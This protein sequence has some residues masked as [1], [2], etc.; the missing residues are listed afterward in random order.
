MTS[1]RDNKKA[2]QWK[3]RILTVLDKFYE[4]V[5]HKF[6]MKLSKKLGVIIVVTFVGIVIVGSTSIV[7]MYRLDSKMEQTMTV[8]LVEMQ[9]AGDMQITA[10]DYD[11]KI[12]GYIRDDN[13][14][15]RQMVMGQIDKLDKSIQ[16]DL[17]Q[18]A[19]L[20]TSDPVQSKNLNELK[21]N[22]QAYKDAQKKVLG[23]ADGGSAVIAF[24]LWEGNMAASHKKL[25]DTLDKINHDNQQVVKGSKSL[26]D[27][28]YTSS[29]VITLAVIVVIAVFAGALGLATNRYLQRRI[30][31]LVI[32]NDVLA[33]GD[34]TIDP[35]IVSHD[36]F[37]QLATSTTKV[38]ANLREIIGQ[39]GSASYQ[40]AAASQRMATSV[41]ESSRASE[42][43]AATIQEVAEGANRQVE[44]SQES[45]ELMQ[46][47]AESVGAIKMTMDQVV[48]MAQETAETAL[49]GRDVLNG[50]S[51]QIEGIRTANV[52]TVSAFETLYSEMNRII[53][54][55]NVITE[56]ASQTNLLALNAAIEAA[57][58]GEH[59]RGF[60]VV[61]GEVKKLADQSSTAAQQVRTIVDASRQ[62]LEQMKHALSGTNKRVDDGVQQMQRTNEGFETIVFSVEEMVE[63]IRVVADT[64][65]HIANNANQV[66]ANIEDVASVVE[67]S[68]AGMQEVSAATEEQLAGMQEISSS[69]VTLAQ[70][71]EQM[72]HAV[73]R[74]KVEESAFT[75][76]NWEANA[77]SEA[78]AFEAEA[79]AG[80]AFE[81]ADEFGAESNAFEA[82]EF[83][84]ESN[85]FEA[86]EFGVESN[87]F[88]ET[89]DFGAGS[90]AFAE[91]NDFGA[92]SNAFE[93]VNDFGAES[94]AFEAN[95]F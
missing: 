67:E 6:K 36:E 86:N 31:R 12:V 29:W 39:V 87:A 7:Q 60:A 10:A 48:E 76:S 26:F 78:N 35:E 21:T 46:L 38:I 65:E 64:T 24:Q 53:E 40:L 62:G 73:N 34:L 43:V 19:A 3:T 57:R 84:A 23:Q 70:L 94:N 68:A 33:S 41:D 32:V 47:L 16:A 11:R 44:R 52:E 90:N 49:M 9:L 75:T 71:A 93:E 42:S 74:F 54:F 8:N 20:A 55:V 59:G 1:E 82:N 79:A 69:A 72:D 58:A 27:S 37:G 30:K 80:A 4:G 17:N 13:K 83:G 22:W 95:E 85:A 14:T 91:A 51:E 25:N 88:E 77:Y 5:D 61:A 50:T 56:I 45:A 63:Q 18:Y 15:T 92:E 28:T 89:N 66:L 2:A 81:V